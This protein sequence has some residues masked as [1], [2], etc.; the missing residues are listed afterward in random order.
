MPEGI[1]ARTENPDGFDNV[2]AHYDEHEA[3]AAAKAAAKAQPPEAKPPSE[4][5]NF[6]DLPIDGKVQL[7]AKGGIKLDAAKMATEDAQDKVAEA[8]KAAAGK[9]GSGKPAQVAG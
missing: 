7:A 8:A 9:N 3:Q 1:R 5:I 4:S 2:M 6:K